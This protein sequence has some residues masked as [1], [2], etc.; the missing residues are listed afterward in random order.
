MIWIIL[1][2]IAWVACVIALIR[3]PQKQD[4]DDEN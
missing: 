1:S 3:L 4:N 2:A